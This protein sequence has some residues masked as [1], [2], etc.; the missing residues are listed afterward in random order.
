M[1][2]Y[3]VLMFPPC[4][5]YRICAEWFRQIIAPLIDLY[6]PMYRNKP[7]IRFQNFEHFAT[8]QAALVCV[9]MMSDPWYEAG[10]EVPT[11]SMQFDLRGSLTMTDEHHHRRCG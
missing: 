2:H 9:G 8:T 10:R 6:T 3:N 4:S 5:I 7:S 11:Q 1:C